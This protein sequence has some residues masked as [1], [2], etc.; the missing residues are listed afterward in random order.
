MDNTRFCSNCGAKLE[1]GDVFCEQCGYKLEPFDSNIE[2]P[3]DLPEKRPYIEPP[4]KS[5]SEPFSRAKEQN[6]G[7]KGGLIVVLAII[8]LAVGGVG[9]WFVTQKGDKNPPK[10]N[11]DVN[12]GVI[13]PEEEASSPATDANNAPDIIANLDLTKSDTYLSKPGL[14]ATFYVV[15]PDG[16]EGVVER[17]S[18]RATGTNEAVLVTE[19]EIVRENGEDFGY[20][21]HYVKRNDGSYFISDGTQF[22]IYP[23]LKDD[24]QIG[25]TWNYKDEFGEITWTV[26]DMGVTLDVGFEKIDN[27]ILVEEDNEAVGIALLTYYAPE[28]GMVSCTDPSGTNQYYKL[29]A[30]DM[31][32][33]SE[34]EAFIIKWCPNYLD[35]KDDGPQGER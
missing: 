15:Y 30:M 19:V 26:K 13:V 32:S 31:I 21:L 27:C 2:S 24:L 7:T 10:D 8:L 6:R 20:G 28:R 29:T 5:M 11:Q 33:Q 9:Y 22:E 1:V 12:Q 23:Y 3:A 16:N 35:I 4:A 17:I 34:A 18:G 14:K 25:K